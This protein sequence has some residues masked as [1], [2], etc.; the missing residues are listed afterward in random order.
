L[1]LLGPPGPQGNDGPQ[2]NSGRI[3]IQGEQGS[4][5][6]TG[7]RGPPGNPGQC[8]GDCYQ[9][10]SQA[11]ALYYQRAQGNQKGP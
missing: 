3:G 6:N 11:N 5:G 4:P 8:P 2:G 1:F 10:M 9:A 7:A